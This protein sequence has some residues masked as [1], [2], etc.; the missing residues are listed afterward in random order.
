MGHWKV[1]QEAPS[2]QNVCLS[3]R[4]PEVYPKAKIQVQRPSL[5]CERKTSSVEVRPG[6]KA[7]NK[8]DFELLLGWMEVNLSQET[9][10]VSVK[11]TA[12][13]VKDWEYL[14]DTL[15]RLS[16]LTF[17]SSYKVGR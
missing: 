4:S 12:I 10:E 5:G 13:N 17:S 16:V 9:L 14:L 8:D 11:H 2:F 6:G 1:E 7:T 15:W 3:L